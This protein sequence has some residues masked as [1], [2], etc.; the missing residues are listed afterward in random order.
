MP[1]CN[2]WG[3]RPRNVVESARVEPLEFGS[4]AYRSVLEPIHNKGLRIAIGV[5]CVC[6]SENILC[7][8]SFES[9]AERTRRKT[10]NKAI[11]VMENESHAVNEWFREEE[12][13]PWIGDNMQEPLDLK[14]TWSK[15]SKR[16]DCKS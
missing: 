6:R 14:P 15:P 12:H 7:E 16:R 2:E 5:F 13:P 3:S 8:S 4:A 9:L 10:I 1:D 11:H